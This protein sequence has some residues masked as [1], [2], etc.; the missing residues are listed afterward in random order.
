M[1]LRPGP[2]LR[3]IATVQV[4]LAERSYDILI[5]GEVLARDDRW[6][7]LV[8]ARQVA[9]VSNLTVA[10]LH[11]APV[12]KAL[13]EHAAQVI[14]VLL[15]DGEAC[16]DW[17]HLQRIFDALLGHRFDRRCVLVALGGGV[18]GDMTGFA[19]ACYQRGVDFIQMP[20]TL[21]AQV[22][23]SVGGKTGINHPAGKNMIGAFHQPRLVV[24][25]TGW[26]ATLPARERSAGLA[27]VIK[28]GAIADVAYLQAVVD[29]LAAL[30]RADPLALQRAVV[31]SCEIK[32][33]V[34]GEDEREN[35]RRAI[36]NFGHTFG[37]AIEAGLG[38]GTWLHGEAVGAG[39]VLA[40]DLSERLGMLPAS[41]RGL[42]V[43]AIAEAGLP[44]RAPDWGFEAYLHWMS[45]DKKARAGIPRFVLLEGLGK[46]VVCTVDA[47]RLRQTLASCTGPPAV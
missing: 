22:D 8:Q 32:A 45:A 19:A 4:A 44:V 33:A 17:Q 43:A 20:T 13:R 41:E 16:K 14:E 47:H 1:S 30:R 46:A 42:L 6:I 10:P 37:H 40:A 36:L 35:D 12:L 29:D 31:R 38:F 24:A 9:L 18:V 11:A 3:A 26:L 7:P 27:E 15:P 5:G 21:L 28:H 34:V 23:S 2:Q 39:M 25:D